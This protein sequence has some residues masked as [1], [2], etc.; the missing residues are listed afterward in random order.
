MTSLRGTLGRLN[1]YFVRPKT[2]VAIIAALLALYAL[3]LFIPQK[4]MFEGIAQYDEWLRS[5]GIIYK[6]ID[7]VGF[8]DIYMSPVTMAALS[9]FF[10]NLIFVMSNRLPSILRRAFIGRGALQGITASH[11]K[12]FGIYRTISVPAGDAGSIM[13]TAS[14]VSRKSGWSVMAPESGTGLLMLKNRFSPLGFLLFHASFILCLLGGLL[15]MYTRFSGELALTEGQ[16]FEGDMNQFRKITKVPRVMKGMESLG[17]MLLKVRHGYENNIAVEL[18]AGVKIR[19][20]S[21]TTDEVMRVNEPVKRGAFTILA[22]DVGV[23]PYF[24]LMDAEGKAV[25]SGYFALKTAKGAEDGFRFPDMP[26]EFTVRFYPDY[27]K[28]KGR[29]ATRSENIKNPVFSI[30]AAKDGWPA[31]EGLIA[32]GEALKVGGYYLSF[33]ELRQWASFIIVREYGA[34]TLMAGFALALIGLMARLV[35]YQRQVWLA[36]EQGTVYMGGRGEYYALAFEAELDALCARLREKL[37]N[38]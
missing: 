13:K 14:E 29:D 12:S 32:R 27:Y 22:D 15:V 1:A 11:V 21:E 20:R 35:F 36:V 9:L 30:K 26:Y 6:A 8:T 3:G 4:W 7:A 25:S 18:D 16:A 23:S 17:I 37:G 19:H 10:M 5:G 24:V 34:G 33:T 28:D 2:T 31:G 38:V